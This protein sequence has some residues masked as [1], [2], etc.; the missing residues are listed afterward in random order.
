MSNSSKVS[1]DTVLLTLQDY[2]ISSSFNIDIQPAIIRQGSE[3]KDFKLFE[4]EEGNEYRGSKGFAN[5]NHFNVNIR[6]Y[7]NPDIRVLKKKDCYVTVQASLPRIVNGFSNREPIDKYELSSSLKYIENGL[8]DIGIKTNIEESKISRIDIFRNAYLEKKFIDYRETIKKAMHFKKGLKTTDYNFETLQWAN[9]SRKYVAYDK[10]AEENAKGQISKNKNSNILRFE[11]RLQKPKVIENALGFN[12][13]KYLSEN[14]DTIEDFYRID[15]EK[16]FKYD[17]I[18][19]LK[20]IQNITYSDIENKLT[21]LYES[22]VKNPI[23]TLERNIGRALIL[24]NLDSETLIKLYTGFV[25]RSKRGSITKHV[26][27]FDYNNNVLGTSE[28]VLLE[29]L[30]EKLL[31]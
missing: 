6:P 30:K 1:V 8:K 14:I 18:E 3:T 26:R 10:I 9:G 29:E 25:S 13:T 2:T 7:T 28:E 23:E 15:L 11:S 19:R 22:K 4:T 16:K 12:N 31:S 24:K 20:S 5:H 27:D 17:E 21:E